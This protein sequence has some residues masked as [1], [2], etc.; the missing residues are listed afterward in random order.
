MIQ[1]VLTILTV[2][3]AAFYLLRMFYAMWKENK[4]KCTG[5]A[6]HQLYMAKQK[7]A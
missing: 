6:V 7:R 4:T 3:G 2:G 5:C 1:N